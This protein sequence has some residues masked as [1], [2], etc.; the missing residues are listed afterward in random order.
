[1]NES[2]VYML[3]NSRAIW[4]EVTEH[5]A[6]FNMAEVSA[7]PL[8]YPEADAK[9]IFVRDDKKQGY[10]LITVR[11]DKKVD[12]K[13]FRQNHNTRA[14]SFASES[15]LATILGLTPG[16]VTPFG[17]L[18]DV[19]RKVQVFIDKKFME[20]PGLIGVHPQ[21]NTRTVWLRIEDLIDIVRDHGSVVHLVEI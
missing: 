2:E 1:M 15:D 19:E 5:E 8:P 10:Y 21:V 11:G 3:L 4:Y 9:N 7:V 17:I 16:T 12:L 20:S 13:E 14:L 6:V 18:N